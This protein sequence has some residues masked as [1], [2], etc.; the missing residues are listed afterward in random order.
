MEAE[1]DTSSDGN[2]TIFSLAS[3]VS[4]TTLTSTR[5]INEPYGANEELVHFL[6][7]E[8]SLTNLYETAARRLDVDRFTRNFSRLL[9]TFSEDLRLEAK[10]EIQTQAVAL[11]RIRAEDAS[12][13]I[14]NSLYP[15]QERI[16]KMK[17][18]KYQPRDTAVQM[19][20]Y[21]RSQR[22]HTLPL[23][24]NLEDP[25]G[26]G[27]SDIMQRKDKDAERASVDEESL[28]LP[29][30]AAVKMFFRESVA[31]QNL[32][33]NF[34]DF[35]LPAP[36]EPLESPAQPLSDNQTDPS[37]KRLTQQ[38]MASSARPAPEE[39]VSS[40]AKN[41][42]SR[43]EEH[44]REYS[45]SVPTA[46]RPDGRRRL[47]IRKEQPD[48]EKVDT[49]HRTLIDADDSIP[50]VDHLSLT[51]STILI[52]HRR[53]IYFTPW[54]LVPRPGI[55][56]RAKRKVEEFLM[57]PIVWWP[58]QPSKVVCPRDYIRISWNCVSPPIGMR[59][60]DL[61]DA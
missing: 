32:V 56:D 8:E 53:V 52:D 16:L 24:P 31:F 35:I 48:E 61:T 54:V 1:S 26:K 49:E 51:R 39:N 14:A 6:E 60:S 22:D 4:E 57:C 50:I 46:A 29:N 17:R 13:A 38:S 5:S 30:L 28:I 47:P 19:E 36:K 18:L 25:S 37:G 45:S 33:R 3:S 59:F 15:N 9:K 41:F 58:L 2:Q 7:T 23:D 21:I 10:D 20:R 43:A 27:E 12:K 42:E 11:V 34:K 40:S 44:T 55:V